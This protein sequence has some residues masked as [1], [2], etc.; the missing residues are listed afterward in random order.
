[1]IKKLIAEVDIDVP[2]SDSN[3]QIM[4]YT[5]IIKASDEFLGF[6]GLDANSLAE[7]ETWSKYL[8]PDSNDSRRFIIDELNADLLTKTAAARKDIEMHTM[9]SYCLSGKQVTTSIVDRK[10]YMLR[11]PA[12]P[13]NHAKK[14]VTEFLKVGTSIQLL[15]KLMEDRKNIQ[16]DYAIKFNN[17]E[18]FQETKIGGTKMLTPKLSTFKDTSRTL[19][20]DGYTLL[21]RGE[22]IIETAEGQSRTPILGDLPLIGGVFRSKYKIKDEYTPLILIHPTVLAQQQVE[23][24]VHRVRPKPMDPND[25]FNEQLEK[26][27]R[28]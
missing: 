3:N 20:P 5:R 21:I 7:S 16:L 8:V 12:E 13:N 6:V 19:I 27:L 15:P 9:P 11:P 18:E 25:H 4:I 24:Q 22:K 28:R 1:M 17:L 10:Y 2:S 14:R 23:Q 26:R